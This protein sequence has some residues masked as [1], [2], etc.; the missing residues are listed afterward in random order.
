MSVQV[1]GNGAPDGVTLGSSTT[2]LVSLYG[3]TP[4]AQRAGA[5]Q[6]SVA[7]TAATNTSPY[8]YSTASQADGIV[9]TLNEIVATLTGIGAWK[10]SA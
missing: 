6:A 1:I 4:V 5:A 10:G 7:T 2:E 3:V 9:T 8:G